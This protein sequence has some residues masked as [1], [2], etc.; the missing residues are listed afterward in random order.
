MKRVFFFMAMALMSMV[1]MAQATSPLVISDIDC[2]G[3]VTVTATPQKKFH[4]EKWQLT[5]DQSQVSTANPWTI[6]NIKADAE[7]DAIFAGNAMV[8]VMVEG[9]DAT[10]VAAVTVA[11]ITEDANN[12]TQF[13]VDNQGDDV[14]MYAVADE[15]YTFKGWRVGSA[16]TLETGTWNTTNTINTF[17]LPSVNADVTVYAVYELK[18]YTVKINFDTTEGSVTKQ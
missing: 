2:D 8:T 4:F 9:K 5:S 10:P 15:C 12:K 3:N 1:T 13:V 18:K 14:T 6:S 11:Y 16:T 17:V 7:Y